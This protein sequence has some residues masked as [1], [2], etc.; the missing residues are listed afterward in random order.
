MRRFFS[1]GIVSRSDEIRNE[2]D[3]SGVAEAMIRAARQRVGRRD[4]AAAMG[5]EDG[6]MGG[7]AADLLETAGID[8]V[9]SFGGRPLQCRGR[10]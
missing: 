2:D 4:E 8:G 10:R 6:G 1:D 5:G 7:R 3:V 9:A